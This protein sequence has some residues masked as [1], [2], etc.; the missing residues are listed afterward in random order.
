MIF[1]ETPLA[2]AYIIDLELREDS[3]GFFARSWCRREFEAHGIV[4]PPVQANISFNRLRGTLRGFHY[5]AAPFGEAKLVRCSRGAIH[6]VI[7]D[8]RPGSPTFGR[9]FAVELAAEAHRLLFV[10][11]GFAQGFQALR[12]DTE[13][14]YQVSQFYTPEAERGI[15]HDDPAFGV[16]WPLPVTVISDKD[17]AWPDFTPA[18]TEAAR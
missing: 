4:A 11:E 13:V 8:L 10:P 7:I 18:P 6:D 3:R 2:G 5:Q 15:R 17:R 14:I 1:H 12:D 16:R 9:H